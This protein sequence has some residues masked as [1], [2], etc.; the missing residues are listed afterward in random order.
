[1]TTPAKPSSEDYAVDSSTDVQPTCDSNDETVHEDSTDTQQDILE[2]ST[3]LQQLSENITDNCTVTN[4]NTGIETR[5]GVSVII[6]VFQ[7]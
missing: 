6:L 7:F 1:M 2:I 5:I 4:N 3:A